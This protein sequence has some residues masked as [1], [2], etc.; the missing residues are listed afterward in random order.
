MLPAL[1]PLQRFANQV[2]NQDIGDASQVLD[3]V[4]DLKISVLVCRAEFDELRMIMDDGFLVEL[5]N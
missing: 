2:F 3:S 1:L 5:L 4:A